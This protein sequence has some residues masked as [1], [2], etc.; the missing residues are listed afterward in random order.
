MSRFT[1]T[2]TNTFEILRTLEC[3][4]AWI[5][6]QISEGEQSHAGNFPADEFDYDG[7][8]FTHKEEVVKFDNII[9]ASE[10]EILVTLMKQLT[11]NGYSLPVHIGKIQHQSDAKNLIDQAAGRARFRLVSPGTLIAEEYVLA[12]QEIK[13]WR[14]AGSPAEAVPMCITDWIDS[15]GMTAEQAA[16]D[17]E[18]QAAAFKAVI[19]QIRNLRLKGKALVNSTADFTLVA[20]AY[21]TQLDAIL[22]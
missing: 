10:K 22:N 21:I 7:T 19:F 13:D 11:S 9:H 15:A 14:A 17:L 1:V 6:L 2:D 8:T 20:N 5:E 16:Q 12:E 3:K 4:P 18:S